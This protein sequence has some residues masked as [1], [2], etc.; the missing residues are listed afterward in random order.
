MDC[1]P[2][3]VVTKI[4]MDMHLSTRKRGKKKDAKKAAEAAAAGKKDE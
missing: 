3:F 2:D 4:I 1:F